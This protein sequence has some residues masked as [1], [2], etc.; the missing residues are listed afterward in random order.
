[1]GEYATIGASVL[2]LLACG[3]FEC[4]DKTNDKIQGAIGSAAEK[5]QERCK[6]VQESKL[7]WE[8][9]LE[10]EIRSR[11]EQERKRDAEQNILRN[12]QQQLQRQM[13]EERELQDNLN[14]DKALEKS[15]ADL[16]SKISGILSR[17]AE[18]FVDGE[19]I[20]NET[21]HQESRM[22][23]TKKNNLENMVGPVKQVVENL[24][25][26]ASYQ[27]QLSNIFSQRATQVIS[28]CEKLQRDIE[29]LVEP[30]EYC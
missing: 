18:L 1:M 4:S 12:V 13:Q 23:A 5:L 15:M 26:A 10:T 28:T 9:K 21:K 22:W 24:R 27:G 17:S 29:K 25:T 19:K 30:C 6:E 7:E 20:Y 16:S 2:G 11:R 8:N 14:K 3:F